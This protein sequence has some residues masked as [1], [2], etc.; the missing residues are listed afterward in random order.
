[1]RCEEGT[2]QMQSLTIHAATAYSAQEIAA[3]MSQF[4]SDLTEANGNYEVTVTLRGGDREIV[5]VLNALELY[6]TARGNGPAQIEFG[7]RDY[8]LHAER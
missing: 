7:G 4:D 2:F 8:T 3:A 1:V 5:D 6:V